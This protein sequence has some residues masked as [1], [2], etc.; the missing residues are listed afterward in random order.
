MVAAPSC[1]GG[2]GLDSHL[3]AF[4]LYQPTT[5]SNAVIVSELIDD[6]RRFPQGARLHFCDGK[7]LVDVSPL[8]RNGNTVLDVRCSDD[9]LPVE[10]L[11]ALKR[12]E[13]P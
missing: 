5:R 4:C 12:R 6:L 8:D 10:L 11:D 7:I 13:L 2:G 3:G 1:L 9:E